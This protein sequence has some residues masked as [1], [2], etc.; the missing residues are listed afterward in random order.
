MRIGLIGAGFA[1]G[2][3]LRA[4]RACGRPTARVVALAGARLDRARRVAGEY[5]I[6]DAYDDYR[7]ILDRPDVDVVD[8]CAPNHLHERMALDALAAG[9]HLIIEKPLTGYFGPSLARQAEPAAADGAT[10]KGTAAPLF[11]AASDAAAVGG[12]SRVTMLREALRSADAILAAAGV[13]PESDGPAGDGLSGSTGSTGSRDTAPLLMYAEN[14]VYAPSIQRAKGLIATADAPILEIRA[15]E[16]HSGSHAAYAKRWREAGGGAL[17]RL[18]A[19]PIG[20][21]L[22]LKRWEGTL[23][24]SGPIRLRSVTCE[25]TDLTRLP[26]F[27]AQ[28]AAQRQWLV[29][30]WEDVENWAC[31]LL[32]FEDGSRA[33]C[34]ASDAVLGGMDDTVQV[35]LANARINCNFTHSSALTVYAPDATVFPGEP[36][37]EKLSTN[38]GWS[39]PA[40]DM[41]YM[42]G[43]A[44]EI[45]DFVAAVAEHRPP[46]SDAGLGRAVVEAIY[47][48]YLSAAEGRRIDLPVHLP[49]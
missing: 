18:G 37:Q 34:L 19:H 40:I 15:Q 1:A 49:A 20:A 9:K 22:H 4:Y 29:H 38:A 31:A 25:T 48:A 2:L 6:A 14:F 12:T 39:Y 27:R 21:A 5:G 41:E 42:L 28:S 36:L 46:V 33:T 43:Y 23:R 11:D 16:C 35:Y 17:L 3:H 8:L 24:G 13:P 32:T 44:P 26:A 30:D 10:G 7:R 45:Q 47:C